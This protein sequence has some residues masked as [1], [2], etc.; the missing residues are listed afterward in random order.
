MIINYSSKTS[1]CFVKVIHSSRVSFIKWFRNF[2]CF[3]IISSALMWH[4]SVTSSYN[5][6]N[7]ASTFHLN[8]IHLDTATN[9]VCCVIIVFL[10]TNITT[11]NGI[12]SIHMAFSW[13][14]HCCESISYCSSFK[15]LMIMASLSLCY[16]VYSEMQHRNSNC[17]FMH[18]NMITWSWD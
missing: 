1:Q 17:N 16:M 5:A 15:S 10:V 13:I 3:Q 9:D 14:P 7:S 11:T 8:I 6:T 2:G 4:M 18:H 12:N